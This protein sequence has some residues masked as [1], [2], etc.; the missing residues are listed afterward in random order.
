M[1]GSEQ[2]PPGSE[3]P[4]RRGW[5]RILEL[6]PAW[7]SAIA[8][9]ILALAAAGFFAGRV[10][11]PTTATTG[12]PQ[13]TQTVPKTVT[14]P[15]ATNS[16]P[17]SPWSVYYQTQV[18]IGTVGINFDNNPPS[19]AS[20]DIFYSGSLLESTSNATLAVWPGSAT[21]T[22]AQ[23]QNWVTTH[24][25]TSIGTVTVGMQICL[26]TAQGRPVLLRIQSV[27][28]DA[29]NGQVTVW[30]SNS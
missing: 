11:A 2:P 23:C 22:P 1:S 24:P 13:P 29:A 6:G 28:P 17:N 19:S 9:L 30:Q 26:K 8:T 14:A 25:G 7:I 27:T 10:T 18:G 12:T 4:P 3:Q 5:A 16:L 15:S 20:A 21:P